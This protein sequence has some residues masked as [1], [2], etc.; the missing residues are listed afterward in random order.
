MI[1]G[2]G[3]QELPKTKR[4]SDR[5]FWERYSGHPLTDEDI[6]EIRSNLIALYEFLA[7]LALT[8]AVP[9]K[10]VAGRVIPACGGDIVGLR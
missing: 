5:E 9:G 4:E 1:S 8:D 2:D 10:V 7:E 6:A 3:Q